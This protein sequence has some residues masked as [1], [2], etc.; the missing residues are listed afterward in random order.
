M[1]NG[2]DLNKIHFNLVKLICAFELHSG[3]VLSLWGTV[4][5]YCMHIIYR[6]LGIDSFWSC[7]ERFMKNFEL[8]NN[9]DITKSNT[10]VSKYWERKIKQIIKNYMKSVYIMYIIFRFYDVLQYCVPMYRVYNNYNNAIL[11]I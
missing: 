7:G 5:N 10:A 2:Y 6:W 3:Y 11:M 4:I 8:L 1:N 9:L